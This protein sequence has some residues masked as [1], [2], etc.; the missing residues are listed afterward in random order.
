MSILTL[1]LNCGTIPSHTK[2]KKLILET[3]KAKCLP[4]SPLSYSLFFVVG[5]G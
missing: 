5:F 3:G 1:S 2:D 4:Y